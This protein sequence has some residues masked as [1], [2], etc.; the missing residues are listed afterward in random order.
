MGGGA[1]P[2]ARHGNPRHGTDAKAAEG[3]NGFAADEERRSPPA[4]T[5][6]PWDWDLERDLLS[7]SPEVYRLHGLQPPHDIDG[8]LLTGPVSGAAWFESLRPENRQAV[9]D[10]LR[11]TLAAGSGEH[12]YKIRSG[13]RSRWLR[14][15]AEILRGP[16]GRIIRVVGFTHDVTAGKRADAQRRQ[17]Q[18]ELAL[19]RSILQRVAA[20]E[21]LPETLVRLCRYVEDQLP[22]AMCTI[23]LLDRAAGVLRHGACPTL[24]PA[25]SDEIDGLPVGEGMAACGTSAARGEPVIV[26]DV[27]SDPL[28]AAFVDIAVPYDIASVWSHPL[29]KSGG[30]V[31]GTFAVYRSNRF[32]PPQAEQQLVTMVG[33]LA[34]MAID[35]SRA[36]AALR[37]AANYDSLTGLPNRSRFLETVNRQLQDA[38]RRL[39]VLFIEIDRFEQ[40]ND[41]FGHIA[42]DRVLMEVGRRLREVTGGSGLASRFGGYTFTMMAPFADPRQLKELSVRVLDAIGQPL[43]LDGAEFVLTA[44]IGIATNEHPTDAY[45]LVRDADVA[46]YASRAAGHGRTQVYDRKLR[47]EVVARLTRETELRR[48][49]DHG[50]LVMYYQPIMSLERRCWSGVE[51][52]VRWQHPERGLM[53][54]G[55]FIPLAEDAGLIVPLGAEVMRLV[56]EQ[57]R[58]W[59]TKLPRL[60][61]G[62]NASVLQLARTDMADAVMSMIDYAEMDPGALVVEVTES[63]LMEQLDRTRRTLERLAHAG[64]RVFIDDFGTGYSSIARLGELPISGLKIDKR[65]TRGLGTDP[66][67]LPVVR[68]ISDLARAY[69]LQ[70]VAE[71]I[72]DE[73]ALHAL[74]DL[75]CHYAQGFHLAPPMPADR[76][77]ALLSRPLPA[78]FSPAGPGQPQPA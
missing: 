1:L 69:G 21:P 71:G 39:S 16:D 37:S 30:E 77:Q 9:D 46:L 53:A 47:A 25:F 17:A 5:G 28:T 43:E 7:C 44:S 22:G 2:D 3:Q 41:G 10:V 76:I 64:V 20:G 52:L 8:E 12:E 60:T 57:A 38:E 31:L 40:I 68:A 75:G 78:A 73:S 66:V 61:I 27:M 55:D 50:E 58:L 34:A 32:T 49:L 65:F 4:L 59:A 6:G 72:E 13:R 35:R 54:P 62:V 18:R 42:G 24:P 56:G 14:L 63:A 15:H 19:Q 51:A 48:A 74:P 36:D 70:V 67:V 23:L 45:G 26:H 11:R 33:Y 29:R